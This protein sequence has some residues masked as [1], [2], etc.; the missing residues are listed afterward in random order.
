MKELLREGKRLWLTMCH[1]LDR[2]IVK[3]GI[4]DEGTAPHSGVRIIRFI[5]IVLICYTMIAVLLS[6]L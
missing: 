2:L 5:I 4:E 1:R 3:Y 6:L